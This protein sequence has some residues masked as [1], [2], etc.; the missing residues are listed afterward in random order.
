[1]Y[2]Y[3]DCANTITSP[4]GENWMNLFVNSDRSYDTGWEGYDFIINRSRENGT[5]TV[6]RFYSKEWNEAAIVGEADYTVV[7]NRMVVR[8]AADLLCLNG[9]D[10]FD[11]KWADNSTT[12]G[13]PMEFLDLGDCAP[14]DRYRFRYVLTGGTYSDALLSTSPDGGEPEETTQVPTGTDA[15]TTEATETDAHADRNPVE[16]SLSRV[17]FGTAVRGGWMIFMIADFLLAALIV[18]LLIKTKKGSA[19]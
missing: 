1:V 5:C 14:N 7:D 18:F 15:D 17:S 8:V 12:E 4:E 16:D 10:S 19:V 11:F 6:E 2:F 13:D 9:R 3:V